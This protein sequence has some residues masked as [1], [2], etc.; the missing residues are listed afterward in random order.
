M[1]KKL[2]IFTKSVLLYNDV[3]HT[4]T[5]RTEFRILHAKDSIENKMMPWGNAHTV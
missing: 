2:T 1:I 5:V 3:T 4:H